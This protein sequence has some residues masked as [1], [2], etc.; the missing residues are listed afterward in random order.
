[1][2]MK[3]VLVEMLVSF[4]VLVVP[5]GLDDFF[6]MLKADSNFLSLLLS[7]FPLSFL[8]DKHDHCETAAVLTVIYLLLVV[9]DDAA[10]KVGIGVPQSGHEV[11]QL[12]LIQLTH[13]AEHTLPGFKRS[14]TGV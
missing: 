11:S 2:D 14:E 5:V 7:L 10:H 13:S 6:L 8:K 1:M 4:L 12:F 9:G 3:C